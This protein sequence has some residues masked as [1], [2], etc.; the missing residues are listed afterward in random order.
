V[1]MSTDTIK[2]YDDQDAHKLACPACIEA[3]ATVVKEG[4]EFVPEYA[5]HK[6]TF[7]QLEDHLNSNK[8]SREQLIEVALRAAAFLYPHAF[9]KIE[10]I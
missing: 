9:E 10:G 8:H 7:E 3:A 1:K 5:L 2:N 4:Q 6:Y